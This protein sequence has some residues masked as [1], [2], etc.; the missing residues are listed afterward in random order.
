MLIFLNRPA[1]K[2]NGAS[3]S[4][5]YKHID[6]K[7]VPVRAM[8]AYGGLI[9]IAALTHCTI[10]LVGGGDWSSSCFCRFITGKAPP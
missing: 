9:G 2:N 7:V 3:A 6:S 10:E 4:E 1:L 5:A 8:K